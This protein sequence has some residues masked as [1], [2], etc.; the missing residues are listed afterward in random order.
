MVGT[1]QTR[2]NQNSTENGEAKEL[3]CMNNGH[4]L[5]WGNAGAGWRGNKEEKKMGQL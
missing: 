3:I 1:K 2:G 5:K 4:E